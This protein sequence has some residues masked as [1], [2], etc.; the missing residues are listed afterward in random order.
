MSPG[1]LSVDDDKGLPPLSSPTVNEST[2]RHQELLHPILLNIA[3]NLPQGPQNLGPR[4][5]GEEA[6]R[7]PFRVFSQCVKS[8]S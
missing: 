8:S 6:P 3:H 7:R 4:A 1:L 5:A 2:L